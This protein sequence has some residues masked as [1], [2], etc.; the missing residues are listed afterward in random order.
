MHALV[1]RVATAVERKTL[2]VGLGKTGLS[3]ARY[4]ARQGVRV[5]ITDTLEAPPELAR[6]RDE[7]PDIALFLGGF[8]REVFD[9]AEQ[10][11]LSPGVSLADPFVRSALDRGV[12][13]I[14]DIELFARVVRAP[15]VA[16]T[17]SNGK[18]TVVTLLGEMVQDAGI[19]AGVG[20]NLGEPALNLLDP[21]QRLY[22]LELSS[23]QLETTRSLRPRAA[24]VLNIS[25]D[26]MDRY[27]T[28]DAYAAAKARI[29]QDRKSVV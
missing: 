25:P 8:R 19:R 1:G 4:L 24:A 16:V 6:L 17:G 29:F 23:F 13:V 21:Q 3:C 5:A 27:P 7:L 2:I 9:V 15:V 11:L 28:L 20:G 18:S 22:V 10:L 26:H 14:G 12:P